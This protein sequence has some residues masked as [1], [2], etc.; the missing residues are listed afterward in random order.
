MVIVTLPRVTP[1]VLHQ[2]TEE[3]AENSG[4]EDLGVR[5]YNVQQ[6]LARLQAALEARHESS[7][8]AVGERRRAQEQLENIRK[9]YGSAAG[10]ASKQR[11]QGENTHSAHGH[12]NITHTTI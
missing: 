11:T 9:E 8:A 10:R 5:L 2:V 3:R 6:E 1:C 7:A 4:R 12:R